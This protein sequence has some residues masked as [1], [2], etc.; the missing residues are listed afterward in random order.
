MAPKATSVP[1]FF[2]TRRRH[3]S[4]LRDWSSDVCSSDLPKL[5]HHGKGL[6]APRRHP[7]LRR[8]LRHQPA[9]AVGQIGRASCRERGWLREVGGGWC[10]TR[11]GASRRLGGREYWLVVATRL[12]RSP[13]R[14]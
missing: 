7:P 1:F 4:S 10:E 11:G 6:L 9:G 2:S 12:C 8:D 3:T 13:A 14:P 5:P